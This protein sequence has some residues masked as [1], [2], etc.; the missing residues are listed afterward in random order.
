MLSF[1]LS[2]HLYRVSSKYLDIFTGRH[3][4][5]RMR[6][7]TPLGLFTQTH[8][9]NP[10]VVFPVSRVRGAALTSA[11]WFQP[12]VDPVLK[13]CLPL[14]HH[15]TLACL[16]HPAFLLESFSVSIVPESPG[17][18]SSALLLSRSLILQL[19]ESERVSLVWDF[20]FVLNKLWFIEILLNLA[21][22]IYHLWL[23]YMLKALRHRDWWCRFWSQATWTRSPDPNLLLCE[24]GPIT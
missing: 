6:Q 18:P 9:L 8:V 24:F 19:A 14:S 3:S 4:M 13:V 5:P 22:L 12:G 1:H 21:F 23:Q 10:P 7:W 17:G 15:L 16:A 20:M 11:H 2:F